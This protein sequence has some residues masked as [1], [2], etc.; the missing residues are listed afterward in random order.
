MVNW[1]YKRLYNNQLETGNFHPVYPLEIK[2][3][4]MEKIIRSVTSVRS[5]SYFNHH[6]AS[7]KLTLSYGSY[8]PCL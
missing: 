2:Q 4:L 6:L 8:G 1:D 5:F 7:G 3:G